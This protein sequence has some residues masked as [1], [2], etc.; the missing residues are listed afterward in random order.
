MSGNPTFVFRV[1]GSMRVAG[2]CFVL[3]TA[4]FLAACSNNVSRFD[5][6]AFANNSDDGLTTSS[7]HPVPAEGVYPNGAPANST[8]VVRQDLPPPAA[9]QQEYQPQSQQYASAQPAGVQ[10]APLPPRQNYQTPPPYQPPAP[11]QASYQPS[12]PAKPRPQNKTIHVKSGDTLSQYAR[13]HGVTVDEIMAANDMR[14]SRLR[15]GQELIIPVDGAPPVPEG[16]S[17]SYTVARGDSVSK[18]AREQ[19]ISLDKLIAANDLRRPY[20]LSVGQVLKIP[21]KPQPAI[22]AN[23]QAPVRVASRGSSVPLPSTKPAPDSSV[24]SSPD[25]TSIES[26]RPQKKVAARTKN[27]PKPEPMA[28]N[29]FRWPVRGRI[30]AGFGPRENGKHN[31]G[32]NVA[33]PRGTSIKAAENGVVAYAGSELEPY[34]NLVLIRHA[35]NW[36]TAYAHNDELLVKRGDTVRRGQVIA[37]A[38]QSG[39][40]SQPQLH[41][42]LRKGSKPVDPLSYMANSS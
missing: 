7:L 31:D 36:V 9:S 13:E 18:I 35:N 23:R 4:V 8:A 32:V 2:P 3:S 5:Y 12:V 19:D 26:P 17:R 28:G 30:I 37:K 11:V 21:G 24:S 20:T 25:K 1:P 39:S 42:E 41:F 34:G 40:V 10:R 6:P 27:L 14:N 33:V 16:P 38:G 22:A 29:Q 15:V